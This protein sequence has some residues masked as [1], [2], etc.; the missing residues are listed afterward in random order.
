MYLWAIRLLP[1][2][3]GLQQQ[4]TKSLQ[5]LILLPVQSVFLR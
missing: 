2:D 5:I 4:E 1:E 3:I